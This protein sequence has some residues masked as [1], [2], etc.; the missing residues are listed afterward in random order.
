MAIARRTF[1]SHFCVREYSTFLILVGNS[2]RS[3]QPDRSSPWS[4]SMST[5]LV[6]SGTARLSWRSRAFDD[7]S[8]YFQSP[9][10]L[11]DYA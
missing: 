2:W 8:Q 11:K 3:I 1:C 7:L 10:P 9:L 6:H 4:V 5:F